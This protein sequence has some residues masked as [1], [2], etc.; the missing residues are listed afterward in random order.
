MADQRPIKQT[1]HKHLRAKPGARSSGPGVRG[2]TG[3]LWDV[4]S[5]RTGGVLEGLLRGGEA[6]EVACPAHDAE[7]E[8]RHLAHGTRAAPATYEAL[9]EECR[10][11]KIKV[12]T[13]PWNR[14]PRKIF[15]GGRSNKIFIGFPCARN[16]SLG[17]EE[18]R[19]ALWEHKATYRVGRGVQRPS[20]P[21]GLG[22]CCP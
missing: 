18:F 16:E 22:L 9:V 3:S 8:P 19:R 20:D 14:S 11:L 4:G 2:D 10:G 17:V 1:L 21:R 15:P 6:E 13:P 12:S 7:H 5:R